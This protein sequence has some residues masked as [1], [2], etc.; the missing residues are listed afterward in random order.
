M[1]IS[2]SRAAWPRPMT[3]ET[4]YDRTWVDSVV[5]GRTRVR[6]GLTTEGGVPVRFLVQLEYHI[7]ADRT[8]L[9]GDISRWRPV[10]RFDH[11]RD[12]P[13]YRNVG[14]TGLHLDVLRPDG[15]QVEK[16]AGFPPV[17]LVD[18]IRFADGYLRD[19]HDLLIRR[20]EEWR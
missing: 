14:V 20:F 6:Y 13:A 12:G 10:A 18:A 1:R 7:G 9:E 11:D 15:T 2:P 8:G 16:L 19:H 5:P 4:G 3:R 17:T